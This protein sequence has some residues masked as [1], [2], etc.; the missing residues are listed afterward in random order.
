MNAFDTDILWRAADH[1]PDTSVLADFMRFAGKAA[2]AFDQ[3]AYEALNDWAVKQPDAYWSMLWD[4]AGILGDKTGPALRR[5][6]DVPWMR[7]F[8]DAQISY[9][10]NALRRT[11][12]H[13]LDPAIIST[14]QNG[15]DRILTWRDLYDQV[16][17]WVQFLEDSGIR[18]GDR[19]AAYLPN[20]PETVILLLAAAHLG[21]VFCS[22]G[23]EMGPSDLTSR[24]GQIEPKL[25]IAA[26]HYV[27]GAKTIDRRDVIAH[28]QTDVPAIE[29]I[30]VLPEALKQIEKLKPQAL[31]FKRR[32]FN[33]PLYI[34]FSSGSTGKPKCF[35]HST[36]GVLLKH[37]GEHQLN[38]DIRPGDRLFYH[39]TPSWMMW[40]WLA[41]ALVSG[42][43]ILMH[44]GSP[45]HPDAYAQW[46]F[47]ARHQCTHHGTAAPVILNWQQAGIDPAQKYDLS[48]L[49]MILST[50]AVLPPQGFHFI[51]DHIKRDVKIA[52]ISGGT[53]IVGCFLGG[54]VLTDT[55]AGQL[56]GPMLGLDVKILNESG[57]AL[58]ADEAGELCC[59]N[60]FPS[61]PLRF[62]N[63]ADGARYRAEYFGH[64]PG[65]HIWRHGDSVRKTP[66]GQFVIIGR[67]DATLNQNGVRIGP[68]VIYD[69]LAA[70]PEITDAAA[71]DFTRPDNQ[72]TITVLFL[73]TQSGGIEEGLQKNIRN[74]IKNNVTPYAIPTEMIAAP[75]ILKT[76]NGKKAEV[77]MKKIM[78]GKPPADRA[79]YGEALV[80]FYEGQHFS[81]QKKYSAAS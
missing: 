1:G 27:H 24:F 62:L 21:A 5:L 37:A 32:A 73:V 35:E 61:M 16:S 14:I 12:T 18:E 28:L 8:P 72:Q 7:F 6:P 2:G 48:S 26:D 80:A 68:S 17:L 56:N 13:P 23:M 52:S 69:Q 38:S 39:A 67:S 36:G 31:N 40:N 22:A 49:R 33:H 10:E 70:F 75:G 53:D 19:V 45:A 44:E 50:G 25:L 77:V 42:A 9:S 81:L 63:D 60:P 43:T 66:D 65:R 76:P 58:Q 30:I 46:D 64:Y 57:E 78:H 55:R 74:A 34:L 51:H 4:F 54:N 59:I 29:K 11:A 71:I 47:T 3:A 15:Q 79:L 20:I 41:G